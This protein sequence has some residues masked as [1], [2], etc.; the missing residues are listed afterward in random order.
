DYSKGILERLEAFRL[1]LKDFQQYREKLVLLMLVVPSRSDVPSYEEHKRKVDELV[2]NINSEYASLG[3]RPVHYYYQQV[4]RDTLCAYYAAADVCLVTSLR[5]GLNLVSKEYVACRT[6]NNGVLILSEMVGAAEELTYAL[7]IHPYDI[8]QMVV[9]M[10][11]ALEMEKSEE[12]AR[13]TALKKKVFGYTV[14]DWLD[15]IFQEV[16][17]MYDELKYSFEQNLSSELAERLMIRF[18]NADSRYILLDCDGCIRELEPYPEMASPGND[19]KELLCALQSVPNT[20][21]LLVSGRS[22]KDM[23]LGFADCGITLIAEHGAWFKENGATWTPLT[24][25][26][27]HDNRALSTIMEKY[28]L[29]L[30]GSFLEE[31]TSGVCLHFKMCIQDQLAETV[32]KLEKEI[33]EHISLNNLPYRYKKSDELFEIHFSDCDKGQAINKFVS[34]SKDAFILAA[35]DDDTDEDMFAALPKTA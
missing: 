30:E 21:V 31:K 19:I 16:F 29:V 10:V 33:T 23:D 13:M 2:G 3:W 18:K 25:S 12:N 14:F 27:V 35:G 24:N 8:K 11:Y 20:Q 1:L 32:N 7:K 28:A 6:K 34:F 5:D 15:T 4:N 22:R 26:R 17:C 9:A